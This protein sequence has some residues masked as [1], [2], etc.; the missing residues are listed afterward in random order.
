MIR[1]FGIHWVLLLVPVPEAPPPPPP[2]VWQAPAWTEAD[3]QGQR[4]RLDAQA[5]EAEAR[6]LEYHARYDAMRREKED[7]AA[8]DLAEARAQEE[9]EFA[10][11]CR[12]TEADR[13]ADPHLAGR[14]YN[15]GTCAPYVAR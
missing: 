14:P 7:R 3:A 10:A 4:D 9:A 5:R 12:K 1:S 11:S 2:V 8:R 13:Q 6:R 15:P